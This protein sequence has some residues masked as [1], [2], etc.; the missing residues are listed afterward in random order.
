MIKNLVFDFGGVIVFLSRESAVKAFESIGLAEAEL[1]LDKYHQRGIFL[2]L[3]EGR[4]S[5]EQYRSKLGALCHRE[6]T[7]KEVQE[8]WMAFITGVD[9]KLINFLQTIRDRYKIYILSNTNP[10]ISSWA[11][12]KDFTPEGK[13]LDEL[14]DGLYLSFQ[15]GT[16]KPDPRIFNELLNKE[17]L[18]SEETLFVDDGKANVEAAERLGMHGLHA[19]V[20]SDWQE[21]LKKITG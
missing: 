8:A 19:E 14:F 15:V 2:E 17:G 9:Y 10:Y 13:S 6:L 18:K 12:S 16:T 5:E 21:E 1:I 11:C 7:F 4:I 3:E 20:G